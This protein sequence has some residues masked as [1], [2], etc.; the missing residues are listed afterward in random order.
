MDSTSVTEPREGLKIMLI[1]D[2]PFM[3]KLLQRML[4]LQGFKFVKSFEGGA[5]ALHA[6]ELEFP[7]VILL[8]LNM[9][10]M[11]GI[12][13]IR[14]LVTRSFTGD[15][16][17]ISGEHER[18][19]QS[20]ERL[21]KAHG[22]NIPGLLQKPVVPENL[23][24]TLALCKT[25]AI[26]QP[27]KS[28]N[29]PT[30]DQLRQAL[31]RGELLNYY[32]PK[33]AVATGQVVGVEALVR[34]QHPTEG[35]I[36]PDHFISLA[37][38]SGLID[39]LTQRVTNLALQQTTSWARNGV[40]VPVSINVSMENLASLDFA[41]ALGAQ[42]KTADV[43]PH[44]ITLEITE[45]RA[46]RDPAVTLDTLA[47]LRLKR[48]NLSID[49][50]GTG[51]SSLAQLRDI[52]F[53]EFKI[54]RS[55]VHRAWVDQRI[56]AMFDAS[57]SLAKQ[58]G[59][60]V[61]AEGVETLKDWEFVGKTGCHYAQGYFI[62]R[63]M[64]GDDIPVWIQEWQERVRK[65]LIPN[66]PPS[67]QIAP[68]ENSPSATILVIEDH[69]FQRRV[70][71]KILQDENYQVVTAASGKE[72][73]NILRKLRPDLILIDIELPDINGI[74]IVRRLRSTVIFKNT[75]IVMISGNNS[76]DMLAA[77]LK[78]G[79]G[80]FLAKPY[81]RKTLLERVTLALKNN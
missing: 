14:H 48:F 68:I 43:M 58:L 35:L 24:A 49:D 12:E 79:A 51:H 30:V 71:T 67:V 5:Q 69:E 37:E 60:N 33:V 15:L 44:D 25:S 6:M 23:A 45:S 57:L 75:P 70:Q 7:E 28:V 18:M 47:R 62:A 66:A 1:D 9:P 55:F 64:P 42:V 13:F 21:V 63:P 36:S 32:Q 77:S 19:L 38:D 40:N 53:D 4:A 34:W 65:E 80:G 52:P 26:A 20:A 17:L 74:E 27:K 73:L 41:D 78:A 59:M 22:I 11:D 29:N 2:D 54:D 50:F 56:K 8:D 81:D 72:A 31:E 10:D 3:L 61:V 76:K 39:L 46:M 16:I